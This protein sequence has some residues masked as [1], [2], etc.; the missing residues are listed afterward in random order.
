[1]KAITLIKPYFREN[2]SKIFIGLI[3]LIIVDVLQLLI[4]RL[5]KWTVD[6][7][8]ALPAGQPFAWGRTRSPYPNPGS[9]GSWIAWELAR[10]G[11]VDVAVY[12]VSGRRV[13][14]RSLPE[15]NPGAGSLRW[16]GVDMRGE[17]LPSGV[18]FARVRAV[19]RPLG[20]ETLVLRR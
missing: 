15:Q 13:W 12:T 3:C 18:Y 6:D 16:D 8:T 7:L 5:I 17:P 20:S 10:G 11:S 19:G 2:R 4:P 9:D 1:M 14:S